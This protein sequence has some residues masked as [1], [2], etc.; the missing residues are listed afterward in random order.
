MA[1]KPEAAAARSIS[2]DAVRKATGKSWEHWFKV[3]DKFDV[4]ANGHRNAAYHLYEKHNVP[5][6]WSQMV[7][8]EYERAR[9]LRQVNERPDGFQISVSKTI[10]APAF[11]A[12]DAWAKAAKLNKWFTTGAKQKFEEGGAYSN[13]DNDKGVFRRIVMDKLIRFTWENE[14]HSPGTVVE[15]QFEAKPGGKSVVR[16]IHSK[17]S[18]KKCA[19]DMKTGWKWALD[20]LASYLETGKGIRYEKWDESRKAAA[21]RK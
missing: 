17:L 16:V 10:A 18:D 8:V 5:A 15:V 20:S 14:K 1:A 4:Q 6:W 9:G 2:D 3:L 19:D 11:E 12:F 21:G 13:G 7:T